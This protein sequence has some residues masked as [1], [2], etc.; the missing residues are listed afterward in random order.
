MGCISSLTLCSGGLSSGMTGDVENISLSRSSSY[1][2]GRDSYQIDEQNFRDV[3]LHSNEHADVRHH[4]DSDAENFDSNWHT[5]GEVSIDTGWNGG[6]EI[7]Q[8][9]ETE[10]NVSGS[11]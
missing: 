8:Q 5:T 6:G 9:W 4:S 1:R 11:D 7:D 10:R 3:S 2:G